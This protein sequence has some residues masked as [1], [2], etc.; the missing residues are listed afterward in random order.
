MQSVPAVAGYDALGLGAH[1]TWK[2]TRA[3][4][5]G[6]SAWGGR[7]LAEAD[8]FIDSPAGQVALGSPWQ[9]GFKGVLALH[10]D[11]EFFR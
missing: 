10:V 2:F 9:P 3:F 11:F 1:A 6:V 4:G 7:T 8:F 5:A